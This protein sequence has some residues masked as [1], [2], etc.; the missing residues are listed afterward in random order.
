MR[1]I[2]THSHI[3]RQTWTLSTSPVNCR[4]RCQKLNS[5]PYARRA[6]ADRTSINWRRPSTCDSIRNGAIALPDT[7]KQRLLELRD[8]RISE[9]GVV[10]IKSQAYRSQARNRKAALARL[11]EILATTLRTRKRRI[12]TRPS[13][14]AKENRRAAKQHRSKLKSLRRRVQDD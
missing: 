11:A 13:R 6:Q 4:F 12:W 8:R 2:D 14:K 5:A 9:D 1:I 7:V 3:S 10:I